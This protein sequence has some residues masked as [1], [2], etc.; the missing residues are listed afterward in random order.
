MNEACQEFIT[1]IARAIDAEAPERRLPVRLPNGQQ[2]G[3]QV[4]IDLAE[5]GGPMNRCTLS[6]F[7]VERAPL[8]EAARIEYEHDKKI[9]AETR[10]VYSVQSVRQAKGGWALCE[11]FM[12]DGMNTVREEDFQPIASSKYATETVLKT[13]K[14]WTGYRAWQLSHPK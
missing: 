1:V 8:G 7:D 11:N 4:V 3:Q 10:R 2:I 5:P 13:L 9:E 12:A 14:E 6:I